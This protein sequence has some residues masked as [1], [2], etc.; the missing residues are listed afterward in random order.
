[1]TKLTTFGRNISIRFEFYLLWKFGSKC[2]IN[3]KFDNIP[4]V[5]IQCGQAGR[6][7]RFG[8][9]TLP[10]SYLK[11]PKSVLP[12]GLFS[13]EIWTL[14]Y[15]DPTYCESTC[16]TNWYT[17]AS[18]TQKPF[19]IDTWNLV[20]KEFGNFSVTY[21][22]QISVIFHMWQMLRPP[23]F[24]NLYTC[25]S[26]YGPWWNLDL[27]CMFVGRTLKFGLWTPLIYYLRC[28]NFVLPTGLTSIWTLEYPDPP[29]Y[30]STTVRQT[31]I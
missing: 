14:K 27:I 24:F 5:K 12:T 23:I 4:K 25:S 30:R 17:E 2:K 1:V 13:Y 31:G 3:D 7:L 28:S 21:M 29:Y 11:C 10:I 18:I 22:C 26:F 16:V 20:C 15:P 9:W 6:I 8:L 19:E